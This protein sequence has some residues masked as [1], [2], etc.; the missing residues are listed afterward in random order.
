M[1][2]DEAAFWI[3][4]SLGILSAFC[5][6]ILGIV[7]YPAFRQAFSVYAKYCSWGIGIGVTVIIFVFGHHFMT[8]L[9]RSK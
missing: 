9:L 6:G 4:F 3:I 5:G 8:R 2:K 7:L 1:A